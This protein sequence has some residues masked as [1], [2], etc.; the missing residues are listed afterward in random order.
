MMA[1]K[2]DIVADGVKAQALMDKHL[3]AAMKAAE[4]YAGA[5]KDAIEAEMFEKALEAKLILAQARTLPG[6]IAACAAAAAS[7][8]ISGTELAKANN[9]DLG[10]VT[11]LGGVDWPG[12]STMGGGGR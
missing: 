1:T 4:R 9:V 2:E 6:Q 3:T 7:L 12:M 11:T 8:H 10:S 5:I